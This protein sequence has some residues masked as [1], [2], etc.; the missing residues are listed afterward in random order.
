M[1]LAYFQHLADKKNLCRKAAYF[2]IQENQLQLAKDLLE[3]SSV[4]T[5]HTTWILSCIL[6]VKEHNE[7][8]ALIALQ[9]ISASDFR[10]KED[11]LGWIIG[12]AQVAQLPRL[13]IKSVEH[14]TSI[15]SGNDHNL[16]KIRLLRQV[17]HVLYI[18]LL[19]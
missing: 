18:V 4:F 14:L 13:Y 3:E 1:G 8:T 16:D 5:D 9:H 12:E 10:S 17:V 2:S 15:S 11:V 6:A 7:D 19:V